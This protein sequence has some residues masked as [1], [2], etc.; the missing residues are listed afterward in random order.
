M[1]VISNTVGIGSTCSPATS[2]NTLPVNSIGQGG[3][4]FVV[5]TIGM[6]GTFGFS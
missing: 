3:A 6:I 1:V 5:A 4:N 2:I